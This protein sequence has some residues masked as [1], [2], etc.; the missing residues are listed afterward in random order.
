[1]IRLGLDI[2][3]IKTGVARGVG[4][5]AEPLVVI[6]ESNLAKL[7]QK[8]TDLTRREQALEVVIGLPSGEMEKIIKQVAD[9]LKH[10]GIKVILWD[11]TLTTYDAQKLAIAS[12]MA[13]VRRKSME[14]AFAAAVMLQSYLETHGD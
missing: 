12:G 11:E 8:I 2:G 7:I 3:K 1:M 4:I 6:K 14:D 10:Q 13:R 9:K 5:L